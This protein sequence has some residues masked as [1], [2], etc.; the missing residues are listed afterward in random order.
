MWR[1]NVKLPHTAI[2]VCYDRR[3][4]FFVTG[5]TVSRTTIRARGSRGREI[6]QGVLTK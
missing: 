5:L 6:R 4:R 2:A 1:S 3:M